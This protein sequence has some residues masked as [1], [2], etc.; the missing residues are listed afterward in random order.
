MHV[1][2]STPKRALKLSLGIS[3]QSLNTIIPNDVIAIIIQINSRVS[4][5]LIFYL[6]LEYSLLGII[7]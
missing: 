4:F 5:E 7:R 1:N 3:W 6:V 2:F